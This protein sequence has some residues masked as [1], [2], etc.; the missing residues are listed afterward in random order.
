MIEYCVVPAAGAS[1][2]MGEWKPLLPWRGSTIIENVIANLLAA[3]LE[4]VVVAGYRGDELHA[5]LDGRPGV[6]L[7]DNPLWR[8]GML[9][10]V[11]RGAL[12]ISGEGFFVMPADMPTVD[13][14][15]YRRLAEVFESRRAESPGREPSLFAAC[16]G[17]PGH[18][19]LVPSRLVEA[20]SRLD[21]GGKLRD[22]LFAGAWEPVETADPSVLSDIDTPEEYRAAM[23]REER[24]AEGP[25]RPRPW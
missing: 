13:P 23:A 12:E 3:N 2:R 8:D 14:S 18:P 11:L 22:F 6:R 25:A 16:N 5:L 7:V 10:S 19:V 4:A 1:S 15:L 20:M 17:S 21:R 24:N 9:G